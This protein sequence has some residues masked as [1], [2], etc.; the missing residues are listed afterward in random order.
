MATDITVN[1]TPA[2]A[3][4]ATIDRAGAPGAPGVVQSV[5][6]GTGISV[7]GTAAAPSVTLNTAS[8]AEMI[9]GTLTTKAG[10]PASA[11][12]S[13]ASPVGSVYYVHPAAGNDTY[14][15]RSF[16]SAKATLAAAI[17]AASPGS[18]IRLLP[19]THL[20][21]NLTSKNDIKVV[22]C[23]TFET[24]VRFTSTIGNVIDLT[25]CSDN[26]WRDM[27]LVPNNV[28]KTAGALFKLGGSGNKNRFENLY[29]SSPFQGFNIE[30]SDITLRDIVFA[31]YNAT[32]PWDYAIG[33]TSVAATA[34]TMSKVVAVAVGQAGMPNGFIYLADGTSSINISDVIYS[35]PNSGLNGVVGLNIASA[36]WVYVNSCEFESGTTI[37]ACK[38]T[39]PSYGI[40]SYFNH[41][42]GLR[43]VVLSGT[44][45][46]VN[47]IGGEFIKSYQHGI[48]IMGG[49]HISVRDVFFMDTGQQTTN[50]YDGIRVDAGV[51]DFDISD[52]VFGTS[53]LG[54]GNVAKYGVNVIAGVSDRYQIV[55]NRF[56][57]IGTAAVFDGGSGLRKTVRSNV[58]QE[59]SIDTASAPS[60][61]G[62]AGEYWAPPIQ[63]A[64]SGLIDG[65]LYTYPVYVPRDCTIDRIG[66]EVTAAAA[67]S[68]ITLG[69]YADNGSGRPGA[70]VLD[71]GTINGNSATA[72]E[73]V[74]NQ[75][76]TGD[77]IYHLV[78]LCDGGAPTV[79]TTNT[80]VS[81]FRG[82]TSSLAEAVGGNTWHG[83]FQAGI[84]G[85]ALP[86]PAVTT[87]VLASAPIIAVR[88]V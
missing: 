52:N 58:S 46:Y 62:I 69:I 14:D 30:S 87:S 57:N 37:D 50:T 13:Y 2:V 41:F 17:S 10:T 16:G 43:G 38:I 24:A 3:L 70:L 88:F 7:A 48:H 80:T 67:A 22:G 9:A 42:I 60:M 39:G 56:P 55:N 35:C 76:L 28:Q 33:V 21:S 59:H 25:N 61:F 65:F 78:M 72:Q 8:D 31:D 74:I 71:A 66:A 85:V 18:E 32:W 40:H 79:R 12:K 44:P 19:G 26:I 47:I 53:P 34:I 86:N 4:T 23:G 81:G 82:R 73:I 77:R 64:T 15:G 83:R 20:V 68:T 54:N 29:I 27:A 51:N 6:A 63:R 1:L 49:K 75:R 84:I 11:K 45:E 5:V 36:S